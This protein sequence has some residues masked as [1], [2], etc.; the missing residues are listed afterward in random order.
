MSNRSVDFFA[1]QFERQIAAADYQLNPFEQWTLPHL[2][3]RV[4]DLGCGLGNLAFEAASRGHEVTAL[5]ACP[6]AVADL[7]RRAW[8]NQLA[9]RVEAAD[10]SDWRAEETYD[11]VIA[12]GLL[13]FFT[14][15]DARRVLQ[16]VRRA[17]RPGGVAA[18]N[19]LIEGT[20]YLQMFDPAHYFLFP[21]DE[22]RSSFS[23]WTFCI[24]R[25]DDFP[26]PDNLLKRFATVVARRPHA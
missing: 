6:D 8:A 5:D 24:D 16:E 2:K 4:L 18:V 11:T 10:L 15:D 23:G 1:Q 19:V 9:I 25:I 14:C 26:A 21:P 20:T 12:I 22:L 3:G 17:V 7:D 13:M